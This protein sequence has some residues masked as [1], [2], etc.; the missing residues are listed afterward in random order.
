M[1]KYIDLFFQLRAGVINANYKSTAIVS[2]T[3][4][5]EIILLVSVFI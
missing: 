1:P 5:L 4:G 3:T 2:I